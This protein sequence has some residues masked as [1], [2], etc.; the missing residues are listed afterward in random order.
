MFFAASNDPPSRLSPQA[1][2]TWSRARDVSATIYDDVDTWGPENDREVATRVVQDQYVNGRAVRR[3]FGEPIILPNPGRS[4]VA[5]G[6]LLEMHVWDTRRQSIVVHRYSPQNA[7]PLIWSQQ[8]KA[9]YALPGRPLPVP[10]VRATALPAAYRLFRRW[11]DGKYPKGASEYN[12]P[13][14]QLG[15]PQIAVAI[16]Y[17]SDKFHEDG[18]RHSYIHHFEKGVMCYTTPG[19]VPQA[20]FVR[21][22]RL[23]LTPDGLDH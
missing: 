5:L 2:L 19:R 12:I 3:N 10:T 21:G 20:F 6:T 4:T 16:C 9:C 22:G 13:R 14:L 8:L 18:D 1:S 17:W 11:S 23:I 15:A 7:P